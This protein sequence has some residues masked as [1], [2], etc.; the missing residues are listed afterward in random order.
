MLDRL[1]REALKRLAKECSAPIPPPDDVFIW[2]AQKRK[3]DD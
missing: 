2:L 1:I 3:D